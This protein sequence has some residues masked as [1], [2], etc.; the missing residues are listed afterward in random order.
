MR[1]CTF[2]HAYIT[3]IH[4]HTHTHL[5][6]VELPVLRRIVLLRQTHHEGVEVPTHTHTFIR[7]ESQIASGRWAE[8]GCVWKHAVDMTVAVTDTDTHTPRHRHR[9]IHTDTDTDTDTHKDT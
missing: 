2:M 3:I 4:T 5:H 9:H 8:K 1:M 7:T 6:N